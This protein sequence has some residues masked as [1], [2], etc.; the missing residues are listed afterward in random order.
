[1]SLQ[2]ELLEYIERKKS[3]YTY[4]GN[5][6][7]WNTG[8]ITDDLPIYRSIYNPK[9]ERQVVYFEYRF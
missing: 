1:M 2:K 4:M 6:L 9:K 5:T 8:L 3:K 7:F